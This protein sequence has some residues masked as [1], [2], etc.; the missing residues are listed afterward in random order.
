VIAGNATERPA[1]TLGVRPDVADLLALRHGLG[2][3]PPARRP[4]S[5]GRPGNQT[6]AAYGRGLEFAETRPWQPGDDRRAFDWRQLARHGRPYTKRFHAEHDRQ[7]LI[8]VDRSPAMDFGTR[9][10]FKSVTAC[11]LAALLAWQALAAGE[12]VGGGV[13]RSNSHRLRQPLPR[14]PGVL[15]LIGALVDED[16]DVTAAA[17]G[18]TTLLKAMIAAARHDDAV[19]LL[20]D[21]R[22]IGPAETAL[23]IR[24]G[25]RGPLTLWQVTDPFETAPP[26]TGVL[27]LGTQVPWL[28][29]SR[30]TD[31][32]ALMA[33]QR[34]RTRRVMQVARQ[35]GAR[36]CPIS[37][38]ADL[39][40]C[41]AGTGACGS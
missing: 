3:R 34:E 8:A 10:A 39:H 15:G 36:L 40:A 32:Q 12:R 22:D 2:Q 25:R 5:A 27:A 29:L 11:R 14:Q 28:D 19:H 35:A 24:L 37:T 23:L 41:L 18:L 9:V 38:D 21:F 16:P 13:W 33:P 1:A 17:G 30:P 26:T 31:R 20:S 6:V 4:A 7:V